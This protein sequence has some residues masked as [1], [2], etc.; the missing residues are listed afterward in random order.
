MK[1]ELMR[2]SA[3]LP[4]NYGE[5]K[6]L[7]YYDMASLAEG[8]YKDLDK[9]LMITKRFGKNRL[10]K[11]FMAGTLLLLVV[12]AMFGIAGHNIFKLDVGVL[13][14]G[15][16]LFAAPMV[17]A[18]YYYAKWLGGINIPPMD[19]QSLENIIEHDGIEK[20]YADYKNAEDFGKESR[21]G[22][23]YIFIQNK[24]V[25]RI[26]DIR[27]IDAVI[28]NLNANPGHSISGIYPAFGIFVDDELGEREYPVARLMVHSSKSDEFK[29]LND[30]INE[31]Y[32]ML[33]PLDVDDS[34]GYRPWD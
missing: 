9:Y 30:M 16:L 34:K 17:Y 11:K 29:A 22:R 14:W 28:V 8:R 32:D 26:N 12:L 7:S 6:G 18:V 15:A 24:T 5:K 23:H 3:D 21:I 19:L 20:L 27:K 10:I 25:I 2:Y 1:N 4:E 33:L 13:R 31:R